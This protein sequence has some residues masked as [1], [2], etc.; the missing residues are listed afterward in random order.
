MNK[1]K[2]REIRNYI[3]MGGPEARINALCDAL[4]DEGEKCEWVFEGHGLWT[5]DCGGGMLEYPAS[6][7]CPNCGLEIIVDDYGPDPPWPKVEEFDVG[8]ALSEQYDAEVFVSPKQP[9]LLP[10]PACKGEA[11][12]RPDW[13]CCTNDECRIE[14]P[15]HDPTGEKW[16]ALCRKASDSIGY[17]NAFQDGTRDTAKRWIA[18]VREEIDTARNETRIHACEDILDKMGVSDE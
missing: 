13:A 15:L 1:D 17:H 5:P 7:Y 9:S 3:V 2:I 6:G 10:C 12:Q 14:G 16:N 18:A 8:M 11:T 4:L